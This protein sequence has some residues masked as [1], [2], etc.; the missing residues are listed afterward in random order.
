MTAKLSSIVEHIGGNSVC[1]RDERVNIGS[2]CAGDADGFLRRLSITSILRVER[3]IVPLEAERGVS[4]VLWRRLAGR[5]LR[6]ILQEIGRH[7]V[8]LSFQTSRRLH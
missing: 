7:R 6:A 3:V 5:W 8:P 4:L 1:K 2:Y